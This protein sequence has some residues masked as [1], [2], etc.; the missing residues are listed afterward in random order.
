[1]ERRRKFA[2]H[3]YYSLEVCRSKRNGSLSRWRKRKPLDCGVVRCGV[4]HGDKF[5]AAK[6]RD[7]KKRAAIQF[8]LDAG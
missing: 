1:M 4:C 8:E 2:S 7:N 3:Y 6:A 5:Y